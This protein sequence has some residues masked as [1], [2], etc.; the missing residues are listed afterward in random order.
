LIYSRVL[1]PNFD[2]PIIPPVKPENYHLILA[3]LD[4]ALAVFKRF[5]EDRT[6]DDRELLKRLEIIRSQ[7][8]K[9]ESGHP[10]PLGTRPE[11]VAG[12]RLTD[13]TFDAPVQPSSDSTSPL[14]DRTRVMIADDHDTVRSI[15]RT[16]LTMEGDFEVV[17][18][19]SNGREAVNLAQIHRP[20]IIIM[21][22]TMPMLDGISAT[23]E[24]LQVLP[25]TKVLIFS[26]NQDPA[27]SR[28][29]LAAGAVGFIKKPT[30]RKL[31]IT[32]MRDAVRI[33]SAPVPA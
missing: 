2:L 27:A 11:P 20:D 31:L 30:S 1:I 9:A 16:L 33:K 32:A 26:A 13:P 3:A 25:E 23:R 22:M 6:A 4:Q 18:E 19:A 14:P 7:V 10:F 17:A 21:D 5:E 29:A 28:A 12:A 24:V 15:V 8:L